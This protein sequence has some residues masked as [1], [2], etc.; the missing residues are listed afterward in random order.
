MN[1]VIGMSEEARLREMQND[2]YEDRET[3][4]LGNVLKLREISEVARGKKKLPSAAEILDFQK[5]RAKKAVKKKA[6]NLAESAGKGILN[7]IFGKK[8]GDKVYGK[9]HDI[10]AYRIVK[11]STERYL[12]GY[13][14]LEFHPAE[15][16]SSALEYNGKAVL[17]RQDGRVS[18]YTDNPEKALGSEYDG[19]VEKSGMTK[20]QF[21]WAFKEYVKIHEN[22]EAV[23]QRYTLQDELNEDEHGKLQAYTLKS[24]KHNENPAAQDIYKVAVLIDGKRNDEFGQKI[25]KY[26]TE[27]IREDMSSLFWGT[28]ANNEYA[29]VSRAA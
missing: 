24:L 14:A 17:G 5:A 15:Y 4:S 11:F 10:N 1:W 27:D 19:L 2:L 22:N 18:F 25:R 26:A 16:G 3:V 28:P 23:Y 12:S 7:Y 13:S 21:D 8:Y 29:L 9:I 20:E 6:R